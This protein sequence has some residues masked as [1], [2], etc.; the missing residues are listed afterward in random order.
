MNQSDEI[1]DW[2]NALGSEVA[3]QVDTRWKDEVSR[4]LALASIIAQLF[5]TAAHF[6]P[7][8]RLIGLFEILFSK[9]AAG[10][11]DDI[12]VT[13]TMKRVVPMRIL[14]RGE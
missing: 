9:E 6:I 8:D 10:G 3:R 4:N 13:L 1:C 11:R 14:R 7:P 2:A 12:E 5:R